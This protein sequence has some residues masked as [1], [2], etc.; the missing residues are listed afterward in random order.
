MY[1]G[2]PPKIRRNSFRKIIRI[3]IIETCNFQI[4][5]SKMLYHSYLLHNLKMYKPQYHQD[6]GLRMAFSATLISMVDCLSPIYSELWRLQIHEFAPFLLVTLKFVNLQPTWQTWAKSFRCNNQNLKFP[7]QS[8]VMMKKLM[9]LLR[10]R[11]AHSFQ[12]IKDMASKFQ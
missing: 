11:K 1:R 10:C 8:K 6:G 2:F 7:I 9:K 4:Y 3:Y 5:W 12:T